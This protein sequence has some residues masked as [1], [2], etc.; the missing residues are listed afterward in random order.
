MRFIKTHKARAPVQI[1][2]RRGRRGRSLCGHCV[3]REEVTD[4][5]LPMISRFYFVERSV[6]SLFHGRHPKAGTPNICSK[7]RN[8]SALLKTEHHSLSHPVLFNPWCPIGSHAHSSAH[9][10]HLVSPLNCTQSILKRIIR[11]TKIAL[12]STESRSGAPMSYFSSATDSCSCSKL[13][14]HIWR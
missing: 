11:C 9:S 13:S 1:R 8:H 7:V 12:L 3:L 4:E 2:D 10:T 14:E 5:R 6:A